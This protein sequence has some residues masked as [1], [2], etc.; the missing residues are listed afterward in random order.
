[1]LSYSC[2]RLSKFTSDKKKVLREKYY[3]YWMPNDLKH[4]NKTQIE[5]WIPDEIKF[6]TKELDHEPTELEL[7]EFI[8]HEPRLSE[9][10]RVWYLHMYPDKIRYKPSY[11]AEEL[12]E[13]LFTIKEVRIQNVAA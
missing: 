8:L 12:Q 2:A 3:H 13:R 5:K 7:V 6:L 10:Y 9:S 1:M 11:N 4:Y